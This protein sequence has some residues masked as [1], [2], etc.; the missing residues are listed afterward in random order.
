MD[1]KDFDITNEDITKNTDTDL[2]LEINNNDEKF[3]K[4]IDENSITN[5]NDN[6]NIDNVVID[7]NI[8]TND[9]NSLINNIGNSK[10]EIEIINKRQIEEENK[11]R[12]EIEN[13]GSAVRFGDMYFNSNNFF[14]FG[15]RE[16]FN[17]KELHEQKQE[18][19]EEWINN[20]DFVN[21][22]NNS[23]LKDEKKKIELLDY[24]NNEDLYN[25]KLKQLLDIEQAKERVDFDMD[26][27]W[28]KTIGS[29]VIDPL[30]LFGEAKIFQT[31]EKASK[32]YSLSKTQSGLLHGL[33][34]APLY[35]SE[36]YYKNVLSYEEEM[37]GVLL[38]SILGGSM[39]AIGGYLTRRTSLIQKEQ[40]YNHFDEIDNTYIND[41]HNIKK[42]IDDID[43]ELKNISKIDNI[44]EININKIKEEH[45]KKNKQIDDKINKYKKEKDIELKNNEKYIKLKSE[46][47]KITKKVKEIC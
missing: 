37:N 34:S 39:N 11:Q 23:G 40:T 9:I 21:L 33:S 17:Y 15:V 27:D 8:E 25:T 24:I 28:Y 45:I 4:I 47:E 30:I 2:N 32:L 1:L 35:A 41:V 26:G 36:E 20:N 16:A 38:S 43:I 18:I 5:Y 46:I 22:I 29:Y 42:E 3:N 10:E 6:K 12:K 7:E 44:E 19:D 31:A 13:L 14:G